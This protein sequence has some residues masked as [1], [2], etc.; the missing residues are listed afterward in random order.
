M[1]DIARAV[2]VQFINEYGPSAQDR[3]L[4]LADATREGGLR[5]ECA[6]FYLI[7]ARMVAGARA[8]AAGRAALA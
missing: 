4:S 5:D 7:V 3:A 1:W 2:A 8:D 6:E